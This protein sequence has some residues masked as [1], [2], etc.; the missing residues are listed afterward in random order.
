MNKIELEPLFSSPLIKTKVLCDD[1]KKVQQDIIFNHH[2][3]NSVLDEIT[4]NKNAVDGLENDNRFVKIKNQIEEIIKFILV[5]LYSTTEID[6]YLSS[7]WSTCCLP[8]ESGEIHFHSN[9][10]YS[11]VFYPFENTQS[12]ICFYSPVQEKFSL[13]ITGNVDRWNQFNVGSYPVKPSQYD[14]LLFP[15]YLKHK[16]MKNNSSEKR[17]S[18]AFNVFIRGELKAPTSNL[19]VR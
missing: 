10:F 11:G 15:S 9:S 7:M 19:I 8:G 16:V 13:D 17:Y 2:E 3:H 1:I 4:L 5:D 14:L 6:Y 18:L 12:D